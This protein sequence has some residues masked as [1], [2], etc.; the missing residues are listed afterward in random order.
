MFGLVVFFY[1]DG[2]LCSQSRKNDAKSYVIAARYINSLKIQSNVTGFPNAINL[3]F[4]KTL[5]KIIKPQVFCMIDD[6]LD[7]LRIIKN[8]IFSTSTPAFN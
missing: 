1:C 2:Q 4:K 5:K 7:H 3:N 6:R 8:L